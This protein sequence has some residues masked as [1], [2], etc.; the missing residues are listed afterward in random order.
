M[1]HDA[2]IQ[3]TIRDALSQLEGILEDMKHLENG[4]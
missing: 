4:L 1:P 3:T 2:H